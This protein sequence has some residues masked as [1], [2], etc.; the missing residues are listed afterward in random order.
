MNSRA[1]KVADVAVV[2]H[3]N[4]GKTS[5]LRTLARDARFGEIDDRPGTT[6]EVRSIELLAEDGPALR[7]FDTPGLEDAVALTEHLAPGTSAVDDPVAR[8][9][10]FVDGDH[11]AGRFEQEA[12]VLR[13]ML[14]SDASLYVIDAREPVL[15]RYRAELRL[16]ADCGKPVLPILNFI[17]AEDADPNA[18]REQLAH[19]GLH[20]V[21]A[22]DTVVFDMAAEARVFQTLGTLLE[23]Q[24]ARIETL[25]AQRQTQRRQ[26]RRRACRTIAA[27]LVDAAGMRRSCPRDAETTT[28]RAEMRDRLRDAEQECIDSLLAG[29][30][31]E[32]GAYQPP[33]LPLSEGRWQLDLFD[34]ETARSLGIRGGSGAA[35]GGAT[36]FGVD[37]MT[38]GLSLGAATLIGAGV[39]ALVGVGDD[40]GRDWLDRLR[41][42]QRLAV[43]TTTLAVLATRQT[44]LLAALLRRGHASQAII[45]TEG[46]HA[47]PSE[48][49]RR[50]VLRARAHPEWSRLNG[51]LADTAG[52]ERTTERIAETLEA[53][54]KAPDA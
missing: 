15:P 21:A 52:A 35:A 9:R 53:T 34:P 27:L 40:L 12:R 39:G 1:P 29:F 13:Q 43:E 30:A 31:F 19:S 38:G 10:T 42:R 33:E 36:G 8:I 50:A 45:A 22:F 6:R 20:L 2:G 25:L 54:L 18:W 32:L 41:G 17:A 4:T 49:L 37:V 51:E 24:R 48:A 7:L 3:T 16:L 5:L 44:Q 23:P 26:Q 46:G 47:W 14:A 28:L 11:G